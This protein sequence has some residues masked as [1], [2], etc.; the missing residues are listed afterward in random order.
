MILIRLENIS[1]YYNGNTVTLG[2]HKINLEFKLG[3]FIAITGESGSGKSTLINVISGFDSYE[4]GEIYINESTTSHFD[5]L[6]W[7][8]HRKNSISF[9]FQNYNLIDSYTVLHNVEVV[10][11]IQGI[12]KKTIRKRAIDIINKVGLSDHIKHKASKLSGGQKQ[13]LAIARAFAKDTPIIIADEPTGNLDTESGLNVLKL[14]NEI[15]R[16]KLVIVV[17]HNYVQVQPYA[18]RKIRMF[19]GEVIEDINLKKECKVTPHIKQ[20]NE[21]PNL[22]STIKISMLNIIEQPKKTSFLLIVTLVSIFFVYFVF[23]AFLSLDFTSHDDSYRIYN[24]YRDRVVV[25][26][27][28]EQPMTPLDYE[29]LSNINEVDYIV[30]EDIGL[31]IRLDSMFTINRS[32]YGQTGFLE[33]FKDYNQEDLIGRL[34]ENEGEILISTY[35]YPEDINEVLES[36]GKDVKF[37]I[38]FGQGDKTYSSYR[39]YKIVGIYPAKEDRT[40]YLLSDEDYT[41]LHHN[42]KISTFG[43][44]LYL[45]NL[46]KH[47]YY[48]YKSILIDNSLEGNQILFVDLLRPKVGQV[49]FND[50]LVSPQNSVELIYQDG[51]LYVSPEI[52][53]SLG[54]D[55]NYQI[56]LF[57]KNYRNVDSV[58]RDLKNSDYHAFS[59]YLNQ[60]TRTDALAL[61][62]I[63]LITTY[64]IILSILII[65]FISYL[66]IK[67]IMITKIRDYTILKT[68]GVGKKTIYQIVRFEIIAYFLISYVI[69]LLI[70][71][72]LGNIFVSITNYY[73]L[74]DYLILT[75]INLFIS[76]LISRR[77]I[78]LLNKNSIISNLVVE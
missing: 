50:M 18:T 17:T 77:F 16:D 9:I 57:L 56:S 32:V 55:D 53:N 30:K 24:P 6:D 67:A 73:I 4:D 22:K 14:L 60:T 54:T 62:L 49:Y 31:D 2:L 38:T 12:D 1:K 75:L 15:S 71:L 25:I 3:E 63:K 74:S 45:K 42:I 21:K 47:N 36:L 76:L 65:Y 69:F 39:Y 51:N 5:E 59:P 37:N 28:D 66:I 20:N 27:K 34:P 44:E 58:V 48:R 11:I 8:K 35:V 78:N 33:N 41:L 23:G 26:R 7:E 19:D 13:R 72:I 64:S 40:K 61:S 10:M 29:K 46:N 70:Y 68:I 43:Y 52:Y